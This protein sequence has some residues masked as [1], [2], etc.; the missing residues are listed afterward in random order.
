[1]GLD[2]QQLFAELQ[3]V[4]HAIETSSAHAKTQA[5]KIS[6]E[7]GA[8]FGGLGK[9]LIQ[10]IAALGIGSQLEQIVHHFSEIQII[11]ERFGVSTTLLQ[12]MAQAAETL[13]IPLEAVAKSFRFLELAREK[14]LANPQ[15]DHAAAFKHAAVSVE[16][17]KTADPAELLTKTGSA[18][19]SATDALKL[20]GKG[21]ADARQLAEGLGSGDVKLG[22]HIVSPTDIARIHQANL[23]IIELKQT[24]TEFGGSAFGGFVSFFQ[25]SIQQVIFG[26][27]GAVE[28]LKGL[29]SAIQAFFAAIKPEIK[30]SSFGIPSVQLGDAKAATGAFEKEIKEGHARAKTFDELQ[31]DEPEVKAIEKRPVNVEQLEEKGDAKEEKKEAKKEEK[32]EA[33][34]AKEAAKDQSS[35]LKDQEKIREKNRKVDEQFAKNPAGLSLGDYATKGSGHVAALAQE[36]QREEALAKQNQLRGDFGHANE[37]QERAEQLKK[38]LGLPSKNDAKDAT[39]K[40]LNEAKVLKDIE[41]NTRDAGKNK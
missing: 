20:F 15:G 27:Y 19:I 14:A 22:T 5:D 18:A 35:E 23:A 41:K 31:P 2:A 36:A 8:G 12:Q 3:A 25:K 34:E 11:S 32:E 16:E 38:S 39:V 26:A 21:F 10:G 6:K 33:K 40:A 4:R 9:N 29:G 24:L 30:F 13:H 28:E 7:A 1:M 17:L 37:H